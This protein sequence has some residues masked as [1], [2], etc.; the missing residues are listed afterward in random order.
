MAKRYLDLCSLK[1]ARDRMKQSFISPGRH[2][3]IP[4]AEAVGRVTA[5][6]LYATYPVPEV[7]IAAMDGIAVKSRDT[8]GAQDQK[9]KQI[10]DFVYV[11][12]GRIVPPS[13]DAVIMIEDTWIEGDACQIRKAAHAWQHVRHA[14]EDIKEGELI[15]PEGHQI[16]PFDVGAIATY[17]IVRLRVRSV[18]VGIIPT[19]SELVTP[20]VRPAPGQVV[21]SNTLLAQ[22]YLSEMG[23]RCTRY[24]IVPDDPDLIAGTLCDALSENDFV[25]ISAGS[26]A[27][28]R[29]YTPEVITSLG[30]M[31]FHGVTIK[32]GKPVMMGKINGKPV[33]GMPGYPLAAQTVIREFAAPLLTM[34]GLSM[35]VHHMVPVQIAQNLTSDPGYDEFIPVSIGIVNNKNWAVSNPRG[36]GIQMAVVRS[37]GYIHIPAELEGY[38]TGQ[39]MTGYLTVSPDILDRSL[40]FVGVRDP[41][42]DELS[43]LIASKNLMIHCC[44]AGNIGGALSLRRNSCHVAPMN[45]PSLDQSWQNPYF[46]LINDIDITRIHIG[47][48]RQ[49]LASMDGS[50]FDEITS[51]RFLNRQ[52]GSTCRLLLDELICRHSLDRSLI[53]GYDIEMGSH[54]ALAAAIRN[55]YADAGFCSSGIAKAYGLAFI[56]M[57][58]ESYELVMRTPAY[59]EDR[60]QEMLQIIRS[61]Q[62][63]ARIE[64]IG[65]YL[66]DKIGSVTRTSPKE[67]REECHAPTD[68]M[69]IS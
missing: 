68:G 32:P 14:G 51:L 29:D 59:S 15:I 12:T 13:Y 56:P 67:T 28:T 49:G 69:M 42:L 25:V 41:A 61:P 58:S 2:E 43:N 23:A 10:T 4:L 1:D 48:I 63:R 64:R 11:N 39:N 31:I 46:K 34:W 54:H 65:G 66:I 55:G 50:T 30:E 57:A 60:I 33:L 20:G 44:N 8:T 27:G 19:G 3:I 6:P 52:K 53:D 35:P 40:L 24:R 7:N 62:F 5:E 36:S 45:I 18:N 9:P 37:N 47:E 17:G 22:A 38:E 16:R 21:E 26:S